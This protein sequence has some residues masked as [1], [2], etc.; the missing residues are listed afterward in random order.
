[1]YELYL[2]EK[3]PK[4]WRR[5]VPGHS[6]TVPYI[7]SSGKKSFTGKKSPI[8]ISWDNM[9]KRCY[10]KPCGTANSSEYYQSLAI[11]VCTRWVEGE[12][13]K[14]GFLCFLEDMGERPEGMTLDRIDST[15]HYTP[16]NCRWAD[17]KTQAT[18]KRKKKAA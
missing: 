7:T 10:G 3:L 8:Y 17:I 5:T 1:M 14:H 2:E 9:I 18:N 11:K 16:D 15:G 4:G 12:H 13:G 6:W